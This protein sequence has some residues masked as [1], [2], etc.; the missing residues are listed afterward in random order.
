MR[1]MKSK[2]LKRFL[3]LFTREMD[4]HPTDKPP[5][6]TVAIASMDPE[7][8]T[9]AEDGSALVRPD[10]PQTVAHSEAGQQEE[11]DYQD[12]DAIQ[13]E[14]HSMFSLTTMLLV[15]L[16]CGVGK[17]VHDNC[18]QGRKG[19][20][21]DKVDY[22]DEDEYGGGLPEK[23]NTLAD[24][25]VTW[26]GMSS[27]S[28]SKSKSNNGWPSQTTGWPPDS[29]DSIK[30]A[31]PTANRTSSRPSTTNR[32]RRSIGGSSKSTAWDGHGLYT[33]KSLIDTDLVRG[34]GSNDVC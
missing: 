29:F 8:V 7:V 4:R 30:S 16:A 12:V 21:Y 25:S 6:K 15:L 19:R 14:D 11:T 18:M 10:F 34:I 3:F 1:E 5:P 28:T 24:Q 23:G 20:E 9:I 17:L 22:E 32:H 2:R 31:P 13:A 26:T 33:K 27:S